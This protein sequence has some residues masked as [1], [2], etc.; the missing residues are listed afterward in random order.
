MNIA[1][2]VLTCE[3]PKG[4]T[5]HL[6]LQSL[7][8]DWLT[9]VVI[10]KDTKRIGQFKAWLCL[11][12]QILQT[13][14]L[15]DAYFLIEDDVVFCQDLREYLD[16]WPTDPKTIALCS[17]YTPTPYMRTTNGWHTENP[18][19][20]MISA[21]SWLIP[22]ATLMRIVNEFGPLRSQPGTLNNSDCMV[23]KWADEQNLS[24]WFHTP[25]LG[26]HIGLGN[27]ATGDP[28]EGEN[29]MDSDFPG[30]DFSCKTLEQT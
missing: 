26:H 3:R 14:P 23:G 4:P 11:S 17:P 18:G 21:C 1:L 5:I 8:G 10:W 15:A 16:H 30:E 27:A 20:C 29:R 2:G 22:R 6:S 19:W 28:S 9:P 13:H 12:E 7:S 25:S 24:I